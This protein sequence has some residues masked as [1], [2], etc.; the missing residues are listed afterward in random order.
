[1]L[2]CLGA[3]LTLLIAPLPLAVR[4]AVAVGLFD[5]AP[6][7]SVLYRAWQCKRFYAPLQAI[8]L[9]HVYFLGRFYA[10]Y[11]LMLC[12]K[13]AFGALRLKPKS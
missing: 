3:L 4:L 11:K 8:V 5:L 2:L 1:M 9:Y 12:R 13:F 6:V 10:L 7:A